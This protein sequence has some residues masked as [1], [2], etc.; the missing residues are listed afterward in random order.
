LAPLRVPN[1]VNV[2]GF[3]SFSLQAWRSGKLGVGGG[4]EL[5]VARFKA[6]K[7]LAQG[8]LPDRLEVALRL[9]RDSRRCPAEGDRF[10]GERRK[11]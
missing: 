4:I 2:T 10:T 9:L 3:G 7:L 5:E 1:F 11:E 6:E 8:L